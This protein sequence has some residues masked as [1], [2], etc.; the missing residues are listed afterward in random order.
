MY[1]AYWDDTKLS[2]ESASKPH[3]RCPAYR[4][5][6]QKHCISSCLKARRHDTATELEDDMLFIVHNGFRAG[7]LIRVP[8]CV[9]E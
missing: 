5:T 7:D 8:L 1:I 3:V 2:G 4:Q 9:A 6:R